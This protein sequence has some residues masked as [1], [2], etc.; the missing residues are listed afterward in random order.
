MEQAEAHVTPKQAVPIFSDKMRWL[1]NEI[2]RRMLVLT[3]AKETSFVQRY[4]L[5]RDLAFFLCM[6]WAGDRAA[7]L[8]RTKTCEITRLDDRD[9]LFNH[10]IGKTVREGDSSLIIIPK[11]DGEDLDPAGAVA[12][13][14]DLTHEHGYNLMDGY[15]FRPSSPSRRGLV[16]KPFTG[17]NPSNRLKVYFSVSP[18]SSDVALRAHGGRAGVA[19]TLRLLGATDQ[20]VMDHCRWATSQTYRHYTRVERVSRRETTV[21]LLRDAIRT[22]GTNQPP[23]ADRAA[24]FYRT[25]NSNFRAERAFQCT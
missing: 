20:Q 7:D 17:N 18:D 25:L 9:L 10:T 23:P 4:I 1:A 8:G 24:E 6:W 19:A 22:D 13:M 11:L 3:K 5:H 15:L 12:R 2:T 16:N 21:R 14:V